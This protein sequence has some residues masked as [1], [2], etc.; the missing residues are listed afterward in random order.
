MKKTLLVAT[1][2]LLAA[3][4]PAALG[5]QTFLINDDFSANTIGTDWQPQG[6]ANYN[7]NTSGFASLGG[8]MHP[9]TVFGDVSPLFGGFKSSISQNFTTGAGG[10]HFLEFDYRFGFFSD[11]V[12]SPEAETVDGGGF[13]PTIG[14][15]VTGPEDSIVSSWIST[16]QTDVRTFEPPDDF[17]LDTDTEYTLTFFHEDTLFNGFTGDA[18]DSII[19]QIGTQFDLDNIKLWTIT[20]D[21]PD[22]TVVPAPGAFLLGSLGV[23]FVGWLRR[24]RRL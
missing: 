9:A 18:V 5:I 19:Y 11:R 6:N 20:D 10:T 3:G 12:V 7:P 1:L 21:K 24:N 4:T 17:D 15:M 23:G 16:T 14:Y 2:A 8:N 22:P 13:E